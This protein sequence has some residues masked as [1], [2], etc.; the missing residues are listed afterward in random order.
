MNY[1]EKYRVLW[2][3]DEF[4]KLTHFIINADNNGIDIDAYKSN[5]EAFQILDKNLEIYDGIILDARFF[6]SK[7]QVKGTEDLTALKRSIERINQY[8][9]RKD[10]PYFILTGQKSVLSNEDFE[11]LFGEIYRKSSRE[12]VGRLFQDIKIAAE[13]SPIRQ[14]RTNNPDIFEIF[15]LDYL[16]LE[17]E[18]QLLEL[19]LMPLPE[20]KAQLKSILSNIRSIHE[21]CL[22]KLEEIG[23]IANAQDSF[24]KINKHLS[25]NKSHESKFKPVTPEYQ[26]SSVEN[27]NNWLYFTCGQY[28][29]NLTQESYK[30]Y[31]ISKYAAESLRQ[32]LLEILLWFKKTY[33]ENKLINDQPTMKN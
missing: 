11:E 23:V 24:R 8:K 33:E 4:E 6:D 5:E 28:I 17:D 25:G 18:K 31:M 3:D 26:N 27:L 13:K 10:L 2:I 14:L 30:E 12:D 16:S 9:S 7:D 1:L 22:I 32:G 15:S 29:H 21:S 19:L 20:T